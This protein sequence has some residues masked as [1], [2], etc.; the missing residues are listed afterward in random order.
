MT[1]SLLGCLQRENPVRLSSKDFEKLSSKDFVRLSSK[2]FQAKKSA[3]W[4]EVKG[5]GVVVS[6]QGKRQSLG[7][8]L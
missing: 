1:S 5:E 6:A 3:F 2:D 4:E 8:G 7:R